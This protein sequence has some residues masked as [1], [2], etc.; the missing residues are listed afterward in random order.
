MGALNGK[1]A[2]VTGA[3]RGIG[4]GIARRS[5]EEDLIAQTDQLGALVAQSLEDR[6]DFRKRLVGRVE[7]EEPGHPVILAR[8]AARARF[9]PHDPRR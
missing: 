4:R 2:L 7:V 3:N 6:P 1:V 5:V 9:R 8:R